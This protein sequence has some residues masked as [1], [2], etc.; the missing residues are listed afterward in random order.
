MSRFVYAQDDLVEVDYRKYD[1]ST[2]IM[3]LIAIE[4][5]EPGTLANILRQA[6]LVNGGWIMKSNVSNRERSIKDQKDLFEWLDKFQTALNEQKGD[7]Q[8][9]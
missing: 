3:A 2:L 6:A 1:S 4:S 9:E 8:Y 5:A 7:A